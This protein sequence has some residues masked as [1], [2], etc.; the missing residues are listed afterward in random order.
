MSKP[1]PLRIYVVD[2]EKLIAMTLAAILI[3]SGFAAFAFT[4]P[5]N[6]LEAAFETPPDLLITDVIMPEMSGIALAIQI[7]S[8]CPE[9]KVLLFSG[10]AATVDLLEVARH[11][12]HDFTLL[13][14]P[15]HPTELL[16]AIRTMVM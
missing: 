5:M 12:G 13:A 14:K 15:V 1:Q 8:T 3:K 6:A 9:S 2:D 10:L 11:D 16:A 4:S 7:K